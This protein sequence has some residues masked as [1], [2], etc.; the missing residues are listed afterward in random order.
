MT[1]LFVVSPL[2]QNKEAVNA[3]EPE[4]T[5]RIRT[6][7]LFSLNMVIIIQWLLIENNAGQWPLKY[8]HRD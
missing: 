3:K 6:L 2:H 4:G 5:K 7:W 8:H 1:G